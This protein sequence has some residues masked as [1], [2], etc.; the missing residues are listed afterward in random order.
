MASAQADSRILKHPI[1]G[2]VDPASRVAVC[3]DV[4]CRRI[5]GSEHPAGSGT[6][7]FHRRDG[8]T[9]LITNWHVL[10]GRKP[11]NPASLL[12]GYPASP[13][14]FRI[15]LPREDDPNHFVPSKIY[16]LYKD[17][18]PV[19]R[20]TKIPG[21]GAAGRADLVAVGFDF[22]GANDR[23]LI[24]PIEQFAPG[25]GDILTIGRDVVIVGYPFGI[26][27]SNPYP[28]WKRAYVASEPSILIGSL[29]KF[30]LD[31]P[32]R[33]GMSGSPIFMLSKEKVFGTTPENHERLKKSLERFESLENAGSALDRIAS[34]DIDALREGAK[35]SREINL[36]RFAGIYSGAVGDKS[37]ED[38]K[39]G[40][41]WHAALVDQL[42]THPVDGENPYPPLQ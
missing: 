37:L 40:V 16:P 10:A 28:I 32:G 24:T 22:S 14:G 41:A 36:L 27:G 35:N 1:I 33:P 39:V 3:I 19:W 38:L 23:L 7:F 29:P 6:G 31:A 9:F 25:K 5:D 42:F 11:E 8:K 34:L 12:D 2:Q 20:E 26:D 15:H 21:V 13:S 4:F 18:K 17:D 30:Y